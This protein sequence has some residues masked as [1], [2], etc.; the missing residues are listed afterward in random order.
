[1]GADRAGPGD[2]FGW[3]PRRHR[4]A[5]G[6]SQEGLAERSG[7]TARAIAN[8]ERGRTARPYPR[9]VRAL[10]DGLDLAEPDRMVLARASRPEALAAS[11]APAGTAQQERVVPRQLSVK[12]C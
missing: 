12:R 4:L 1:M 11:S 2:G 5:A 3:L 10:P 9:S 7:L 8:L 6:L